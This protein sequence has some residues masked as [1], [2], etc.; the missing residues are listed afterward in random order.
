MKPIS[1]HSLNQPP[2]KFAIIGAGISG[3]TAARTLADHGY[4]VEVFEKSR[5]VGGRMATRRTPDGAFDHGAQ[6]FT[7]RDSR[8]QKHVRNW[9][10]LGL[11][12]PWPN[13]DQ[14]EDQNIVSLS[15]GNAAP[16]SNAP[17]RLVAVPAM[18]A[19][20]K[21][22]AQNLT[23]QKNTRI[24]AIDRTPNQ[25]QLIDDTQNLVGRFDQVV[26]STP[27]EQA[28][29]LLKQFTGLAKT[30]S[31]VQ[32]DPC[33]TAMATFKN[34]LSQDW[35]GAFLNE[36]FLT[37][38]A[39]NN[40]K[41]GRTATLDHLILHASPSWSSQ[42]WDEKPDHFFHKML[43]EFWRVSGIP[44]QETVSETTH[45]WKFSVSPSSL[46]RDCLYEPKLG[47]AVCGD[48]VAGNRVEG[49]FLSGKAAADH[50]LNSIVNV[51]Q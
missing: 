29:E 16:V 42:Y 11:V 23:V 14:G 21:H 8:F 45:R 40:S 48:W 22:L 13:G 38:A 3:I 37:W 47:I 2:P 34:P 44:K 10:K 28:A 5:G 12:A 41:P 33:L 35:C 36:S 18:N 7:V 50:I 24:A 20:C 30:I 51:Q 43:N 26:V 27:A 15:G 17:Q 31:T 49:A 39:R 4:P 19:I 6:Y 25:I 9:I 1:Q 46:T 32:M